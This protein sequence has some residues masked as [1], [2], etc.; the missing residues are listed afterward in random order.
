MINPSKLFGGFM[1]LKKLLMVHN[2][3]VVFFMFLAVGFISF[4]LV[5]HPGI[6][7]LSQ[8]TNDLETWVTDGHIFEMV[9]GGDGTVYASGTFEHVGPPHTG[10]AVLVNNTTGLSLPFVNLERQ[11]NVAISDG[12]GGWYI[13]GDF[14]FVDGTP[15][16][17]I[18]HVL[19]DGSRDPAWTVTADSSVST[20]VLSGS[21]LYVSGNFT[22][23]GGEPRNYLGAIDISTGLVTSWDPNLNAPARSMVVSGGLVY[24]GGGF[25]TVGV[26]VRNHLASI[27]EIS[28]LATAFDP[29]VDQDVFTLVVDSGTVYFGGS[30]LTVGVDSRSYIAAVDATTG[31]LLDWLPNTNYIVESMV[32]DGSTL[33]IGGWFT[34][35]DNFGVGVPLSRN[36]LAAID[37]PTGL[38]TAFDPVLTCTYFR[39]NTSPEVRSLVLSGGDLYVGG[40]FDSVYGATR[41]NAAAISTATS[42]VLPW[43]VD[44]SWSVMA[45]G[46][47]GTDV[48]I[49]GYFDLTGAVPRTI[50][51]FDGAT[52]VA[53]AF[54]PIITYTTG[55]PSAIYMAIDGATMYIAG[56]FIAVNGDPR[57][58]LAAIDTVTGATL[59][60]NPTQDG[61][62]YSL[63][64]SGSSVF[65]AGTFHMVNGA[66]R[67]GFAALDGSSGALLG[68]DPVA[69]FPGPQPVD[70][71]L[72]VSGS[73]VYLAGDF[74][75]I[76]GQARTGV[77]AVDTTTGAVDTWNPSIDG[78]VD[79]ID[80][81]GSKLYVAGGFANI[82]ASP[83]AHFAAFDLATGVLDPWSPVVDAESRSKIVPHAGSTF[84]VRSFSNVNGVDISGDLAAVDSATGTITSP[85]VSGISSNA[86]TAVT[87]NGYL[88]VGGSFSR[89][90][91]RSHS[92]LT[93]F[94]LPDAVL[95]ESAGS[96]DVAEGGV[97]D[98]YTVALTNAPDSDVTISVTPDAQITT[99]TALLTFTALNWNTPQTVTVTAVIDPSEGG[100]HVGVISHVITSADADYDGL[101]TSSVTANITD[102]VATSRG[103][104]FYGPDPRHTQL[105]VQ[106][107]NGQEQL[108]GGSIVDVKWSSTATIGF[109]NIAYSSD[110]GGHWMPLA[111][112]LRNQNVYRWTVPTDFS[113]SVALIRVEAT[114]SA[115]V[116]ATDTSDE[117]F[118]I[119]NPKSSVMIS[120]PVSP[121]QSPV[122]VTID[123][124]CTGSAKSAKTAP[125]PVDGSLEKV[126]PTFPGDMIKSPH[127]EN[128]YY[129]T[130]N[131]ERRPYITREAYFTYHKSLNDVVSVTDATLTLL[132]LGSPIN[133][134]A[135]TVLV[136]IQSL[137][138]IYVVE[139]GNQLND[140]IYRKIQD[141]DLV[142]QL[143]GKDW[144]DYVV[145]LDASFV[146][147]M[148]FGEM[149]S[150]PDYQV[151]KSLLIKRIT[152]V[153]R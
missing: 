5:G 99:D 124:V 128:I 97:T 136:R 104:D 95:I 38:P 146:R 56:D 106:N 137:E 4:W 108:I 43:V 72:A 81:F 100:P 83:R 33:Y 147:E 45:V 46:S 92:G 50:A 130:D 138:G 24:V 109:V 53:T 148:Y 125:S 68:W 17:Y 120:E 105:T 35:V 52:G 37:I 143:Y 74:I 70:A 76:G 34:T 63:D 30:F 80:I 44:P 135:Q 58:G 9:V 59:P 67:D 87:S 79:S 141:F 115:V 150:N 90:T 2:V 11:M 28:G 18:A 122:S 57:S 121:D 126:S 47:D 41:F 107:P 110:G 31:A 3:V 8:P 32:I 16:A 102:G 14:E 123:G 140:P 48:V 117:Y 66:W 29:N 139:D 112:L 101:P 22:T 42:T 10:K 82:D 93:R 55:T 86:I 36:G 78:T 49:G 12:A 114:D 20:L 127:F 39:C 65:M 77:A 54:H 26:D 103:A 6:A 118:S 94:R 84:L 132:M 145:I 64:V 85:W 15:Q 71:W 7:L 1:N 134:K 60:W 62:V 88:Y 89:V 13:G 98:S 133:H 23:L 19:A 96:T 73:T 142:E 129:I 119:V 144:R 153:G 113:S 149:I 51:A 75:A 61:S 151:D 111:N 40:V 25:T 69:T 152:L 91:D 131:C 27:D 116:Y 21:I